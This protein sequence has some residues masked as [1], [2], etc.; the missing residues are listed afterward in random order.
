M[1]NR[2][3]VVL[4]AVAV[5]AGCYRAYVLPSR[6][7]PQAVVKVRVSYHSQPGP[8]LSQRVLINGERIEIP[9]PPQGA[10]RGDQPCRTGAAGPDALGCGGDVL[11]RDVGSTAT[12]GT[13]SENYHCG[14]ARAASTCTKSSTRTR[15]V[16]VAHKMIDATC[17]R[18]ML[19]AP[20][21]DG[22]YLVQF[23]FYASGHCTLSCF[24][25]V[26]D[27]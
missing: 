16:W 7:E 18:A 3:V 20:Q 17:S 8:Q 4:A 25:A 6:N 15:T 11:S 1:R 10:P 12:D 24:P 26:A 5:L 21:I 22:V 23:D 19:Q 9:T 27:A 13:Y 2:H 14:Y